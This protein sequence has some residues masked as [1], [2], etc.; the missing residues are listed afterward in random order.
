MYSTYMQH[1]HKCRV[2]LLHTH[3]QEGTH[4][5]TAGRWQLAICA[6]P[7]TSPSASF[8]ALVFALI[9]SRSLY[10]LPFSH[11]LSSY[12]QLSRHR[13]PCYVTTTC[14]LTL[15]MYFFFLSWQI[16]LRCVVA[17]QVFFKIT[18]NWARQTESTEDL[19][20]PHLRFLLCLSLIDVQMRRETI[21]SV[22]KSSRWNTYVREDDIGL[23][24][25]THNRQMKETDEK[26]WS[27]RSECKVVRRER[28]K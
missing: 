6:L 19:V 22:I 7:L 17:S 3:T 1:A 15:Y 28:R 4:T 9:N 2:G 13:F 26:L 16:R 8:Y 18:W 23:G 12:P 27:N 25:H 10:S 14:V 21:R 5:D 11:H 20:N 24:M